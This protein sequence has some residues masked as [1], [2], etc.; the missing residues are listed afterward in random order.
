MQHSYSDNYNSFSDKHHSFSIHLASKYGIECAILI[1]HFQH[2]IEYNQRL[3]RNFYE[4]RTWT[5]QTLKEI[6]AHYPYLDEYSVCRLL[7]KLVKEGIL[8][9]GNFNK[10]K[11]DKT[12]WYA[13]KNEE[14]FTKLQNCNIDIEKVQY[15]DCGSATPIPDTITHTRN[16]LRNRKQPISKISF[17]SFVLLT[18]EEYDS[19]C[20]DFTQQKIDAVI[21]EIN[22]Y[23]EAH[24]KSYKGYAAAIRKWLRKEKDFKPAQS[25]KSQQNPQNE[26]EN[27]ELAKRYEQNL[28]SSTHKIEV[29]S[30]HVEIVAA[31]NTQV[32]CIKYSELGFKEQFENALRKCG[33][34][35]K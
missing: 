9:K 12:Q 29:L 23:C 18:Q 24:G 6:A 1:H 4:G 34:K 11:F 21:V 30:K 27:I 2:W 17:G 19:L 22:D 16:I 28:F 8:I 14:M 25:A 3:K 33:F 15:P 13:F 31:G 20:K 35:K 5:Y 26:Q 32:I 10:S 7:K